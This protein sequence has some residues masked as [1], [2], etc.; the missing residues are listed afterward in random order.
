MQESVRKKQRERESGVATMPG[1]ASVAA[2]PEPQ[3]T[4]NFNLT[5]TALIDLS[6]QPYVCL[7]VRLLECLSVCPSFSSSVNSFSCVRTA[8]PSCPPQQ[9]QQQEYAITA[10]RDSNLLPAPLS[11]PYLYL[12]PDLSLPV[13]FHCQLFCFARFSVCCTNNF[14]AL[15]NLSLPLEARC[16][17]PLAA[18]CR[19]LPVACQRRQFHHLL[20]PKPISISIPKPK[21]RHAT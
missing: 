15:F 7:S 19:M 11:L 20:N 1:N 10:I 8:W 5:K 2:K 9:Q 18:P 6:A 17:L 13:S 3:P 14:R 4:F 12:S 16:L 21:P